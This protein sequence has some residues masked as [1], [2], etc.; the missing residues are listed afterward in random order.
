MTSRIK[1]LILFCAVNIHRCNARTSNAASCCDS[2][3]TEKRSAYR[4]IK[5]VL[6]DFDDISVAQNEIYTNLNSAEPGMYIVV[7]IEIKH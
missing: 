6:R 2:Y 7:V 5:E 3:A 1:V 4:S